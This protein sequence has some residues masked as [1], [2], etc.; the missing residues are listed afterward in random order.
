MYGKL[1][2]PNPPIEQVN[3]YNILVM[4]AKWEL[5]ISYNIDTVD[6]MPHIKPTI[7][8]YPP[9]LWEKYIQEFRKRFNKQTDYIIDEFYFIYQIFIKY[10]K[11]QIYLQMVTCISSLI[12]NAIATSDDNTLTSKFSQL[13]D[14]DLVKT[15]LPSQEFN[16]NTES[17][18]KL[19]TNKWTIDKP[20]IKNFI[21]KFGTQIDDYGSNEFLTIRNDNLYHL[22]CNHEDIISKIINNPDFIEMANG[23]FTEDIKVAFIDILKECSVNPINIKQLIITN[24]QLCNKFAITEFYGINM[25]KFFKSYNEIEL[26]FNNIFDKISKMYENIRVK[27]YI[28]AMNVVEDLL[29]NYIK[30]VHEQLSV[31]QKNGN[32]RIEQIYGDDSM[33]I[34]DK[35][36]K[37]IGDT[38]EKINTGHYKYTSIVFNRLK[39]TINVCNQV[40]EYLNATSSYNIIKKI[41]ENNLVLNV[42]VDEIFSDNF[43]KIINFPLE[44]TATNLEKTK[45]ND[46]IDKHIEMLKKNINYFNNSGQ[47]GGRIRN[48]NLISEQ[49]K[50]R[51]TEPI[52]EQVKVK[53]TSPISEQVKVKFTSPISEQVKVKFTDPIS[54]QVKVKYIK[55]SLKQS[56]GVIG[57][58]VGYFRLTSD[59]IPNS[60]STYVSNLIE[61]LKIRIIEDAVFAIHSGDVKNLFEFFKIT[62]NAN[63]PSESIYMFAVS[64]FDIYLS[65]MI[66]DFAK[67]SVHNWINRKI[68][69][70]NNNNVFFTDNQ[71]FIGLLMNSLDNISQVEYRPDEAEFVINDEDTIHTV[72]KLHLNNIVSNE[73]K[74]KTCYNYNKKMIKQ[75]INPASINAK[76]IDGNTPLHLAVMFRF[77]NIIK[78]L[79]ENG[80]MPNNINNQNKTPNK[81][82]YD[83]LISQIKLTNGDKVSDNIQM[84]NTFN[85]MLMTQINDE[86]YQFNVPEKITMGIPIQ[87]IMYNHMFHI[88]LENYQYGFTKQIKTNIRNILRKYYG[89]VETY[90]PNDFINFNSSE[91]KTLIEKNNLQNQISESKDKNNK[92]DLEINQ[93]NLDN[94]VNQFSESQINPVPDTM[95]AINVIVNKQEKMK[96]DA[97]E[98]ATR[99]QF[100]VA[101]QNIQDWINDL[102]NFPPGKTIAEFHSKNTIQEKNAFLQVWK[103]Y[104]EKN[105][106]SAPSMIFHLL[107]KLIIDNKINN[108][109]LVQINEFYGIFVKF[110][111]MKKDLPNNINEN[112]IIKEEK[113]QIEYLI[114]LIITPVAYNVIANY[115]NSSMKNRDEQFLTRELLELENYLKDKLPSLMYKY[116]TKIYNNNDIDIDKVISSTD[117]LFAPIIELIKV[118]H[119]KI[120]DNDVI[121]TNLKT[122]VFPWLDNI[123]NNFIKY[124]RVAVYGY[125]QHLLNISQLLGTY[126]EINKLN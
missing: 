97:I 119:L 27:K 105:I 22:I 113:E 112:P 33:P 44:I 7:L 8:L 124:I 63:I 34:S 12:E 102:P 29:I 95:K 65:K 85:N 92:Y 39:E 21:D 76:N 48:N 36:T 53:F 87:I 90:Y 56:G 25:V 11:E 42:D 75:L 91:L 31:M 20:L 117:Q 52:S 118:L 94:I 104:I 69:N 2:V 100:I 101:S 38:F 98:S 54:E 23:F 46:A 43:P 35:I 114:N 93:M 60:I 123:Y 61:I 88:F 62:D 40:I 16:A 47:F 26:L 9:N 50:I 89:H 70:T 83:A 96:G 107:N 73:Q 32:F 1:N 14:A 81:I 106:L 3:I 82:A 77:N 4:F 59:N 86:K 72:Y 64:Q 6:L 110:T 28:S 24:N 19:K 115:V 58:H 103:F 108:D 111:Q 41:I 49:V 121:I 30:I 120:D 10:F 109:E 68:T 125:E 99:E 67:R 55:P 18:K 13:S 45:F 17:F 84:F 5:C 15:I 79:K 37:Y 126:V 116:Y 57:R 78:L 51:F 74:D 122:Y 80:A 66:N 71:Q